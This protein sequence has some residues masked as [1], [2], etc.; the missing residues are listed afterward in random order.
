MTKILIADDDLSTRLLV[1]SILAG[2]DYEFIEANDGDSAYDIAVADKP[3][4]ILLDLMMPGMDGFQ[5]LER[6][7]NNI[8]TKPIPIIMLTARR[9]PRDE[10]RGIRL[11]AADYI[12][13][14]CSRE[15]LEDRVR[16]ALV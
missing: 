3:D 4:V 16:L 5:V 13:K 7:K 1:K 8:E 11:G 2:K 14:P 15:E 6:L 10:E 9:T 12:T